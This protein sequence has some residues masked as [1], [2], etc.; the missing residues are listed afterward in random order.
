MV[1]RINYEP[2]FAAIYDREDRRSGSMSLF[3][4]SCFIA[5]LGRDNDMKI[6]SRLGMNLHLNVTADS[7]SAG[8]HCQ[9]LMLCCQHPTRCFQV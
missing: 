5:G 7:R 1:E 4:S 6:F 2:P 8:G 3:L 9:L